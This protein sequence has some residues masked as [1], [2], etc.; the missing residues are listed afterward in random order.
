MRRALSVP[1]PFLSQS[2]AGISPGGQSA[3]ARVC[4]L[5][6]LTLPIVSDDTVRQFPTFAHSLGYVLYENWWKLLSPVASLPWLKFNSIEVL[7]G[8]T[9]VAVLRRT[10][11]AW[12]NIR[13]PFELT[14]AVAFLV[15]VLLMFVWG[16]AS[17]GALKPALW[18]V[19]PYLHLVAIAV[20]IPAVFRTLDDVKLVV[21]LVN[22]AIV[23]KAC[24]VI[25]VFVFAADARF[26]GWRELVGHE[27]LVFFVASFFF[28]VAA[29]AYSDKTIVK[30]CC[31]VVCPILLAAIVLN[32]RRA[33]YVALGANLL[34]LPLFLAGARRLAALLLGAGAGLGSLYLALFWQAEGPLAVPAEKVRSILMQ[35]GGTDASSNAY[36]IG[37]NL[38]L[39]ATVREHPFGTGFGFPFAKIYPLAD[40]GDILP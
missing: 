23:L 15:V 16:L 19:R 34:L 5:A 3:V 25:G 8:V 26:T 22:A 31:A 12:R 13:L 21:V 18:Q 11:P 35:T 2:N 6:L 14:G 36:R 28:A 37:E 10:I 4:M 24:L 38:N 32:L 17:G 39:W 30:I 9:A 20:L 40:I 1:E 7:I 33:G 29:F 27:D